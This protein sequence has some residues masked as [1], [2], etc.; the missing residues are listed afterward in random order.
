MFAIHGSYYNHAL[1]LSGFRKEI[2]YIPDR[3]LEI[4]IGN[5]FNRSGSQSS[6]K[7]PKLDK[8][9]KKSL[10]PEHGI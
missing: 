9:I 5:S 2:F 8:A 3:I 7:T 6:N 4:K 10:S 1:K